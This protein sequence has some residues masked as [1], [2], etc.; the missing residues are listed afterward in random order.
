MKRVLTLLAMSFFTISLVSAQRLL[1][2]DFNYAAGDLTT[3]SGGLWQHYSGNT[4]PIRVVPGN[5]TYPGYTTNPTTETKI[6]LDTA[7]QNGEDAY[8]DFMQVDTGSVYCSFLLNV[9]NN[10]LMLANNSD[11]GE[12]FIS[13]LPAQANKKY[14]GGVAIKKG[15]Q[16]KTIQLGVFARIDPQ[17]GIDWAPQDYAENT[18]LLVTVQ[19]QFVPGNNNNV[20]ALW[21]NPSTTGPQPAPDAQKIDADTGSYPKNIGRLT[22]LQRSLRSP[23]CY[24][25]AI[26]VSTT[27]EDA[28]LP[29]RLLSFNVADNNGNAS[30]TWQTCNELNMK[31]FEVQR[32]ADAQNFA[33]IGTVT[34][35]NGN[36]GTT[37][38]YSDPKQL[39]GTAYYR[40]RMIDKDGRSTLSAIVHVTGKLPAALS[41]FPNPIINDLVL[42]HPKAEAGA[43]IKIVSMNGAV[44]ASYSVQKDV[45]Q[46]SVNV[47]KLAKGNYIVAYQNG[48]QKQTIKIVK[49]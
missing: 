36:C 44:V 13:F 30:L 43:T 9:L 23:L 8:I 3:V 5:L 10:P 16:Q 29:L 38:A 42:S 40:L 4:K 32:S 41:V 20:A 14:V 11:S 17:L 22:L 49:Q 45:V 26:K 21:V 39:A 18:T 27:W 46:T 7:K 2:E 48:Q 28:V 35:K 12:F 34:A 37:Y 15:K 1:T 31:E 19:Y 24:I 25:D 47:S 6:M 33:A